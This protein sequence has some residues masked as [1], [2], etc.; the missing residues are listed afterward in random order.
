[1]RRWINEMAISGV[2]EEGDFRKS[3]QWVALKRKHAGLVVS[4]T[5]LHSK[6]RDYCFLDTRPT[7]M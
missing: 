6:F 5:A 2:V 4:D 3:S 7:P 1:M